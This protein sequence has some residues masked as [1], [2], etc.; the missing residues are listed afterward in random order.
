MQWLIDL[1]Y[2][3]VLDKGVFVNRGDPTAYD[4]TKTDLT[5]DNTWRVLDL[6]AI[7]PFP[8]K[9]VLL[10]ASLNGSHLGVEVKLRPDGHTDVY[11][12]S[13]ATIQVVGI[14]SIFD[15]TLPIS[16]ERKLQYKAK[17]VESYIFYLSVKGWWF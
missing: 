13:L 2:A 1:V 17:P 7:V 4:F 15:F 8:A 10:S 3:M 14:S 5:W 6:S 11:N 9:G 12:A 16:T